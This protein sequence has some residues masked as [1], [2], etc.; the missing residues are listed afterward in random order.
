MALIGV[1][2]DY[3]TAGST[4]GTKA[5]EGTGAAPI[6]IGPLDTATNQESSPLKLAVRC[7]AGY[8]AAG[9]A[10]IAISGATATKWALAPDVEGSAGTFGAYGASLAIATAITAANLIFWAKAKAESTESPLSDT[11]VDL[12]VTATISPV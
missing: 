7:D 11:S 8:A 1:Y 9:G 2:F 12:V 3:P 5:S 6:T 10:T 4:D